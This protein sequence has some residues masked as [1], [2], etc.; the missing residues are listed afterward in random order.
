MFK[1]LLDRLE[2]EQQK[3]SIKEGYMQL[4]V[5]FLLPNI[6]PSRMNGLSCPY[7]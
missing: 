7:M 4:P 6:P 5:P 1:A 3:P 2:V